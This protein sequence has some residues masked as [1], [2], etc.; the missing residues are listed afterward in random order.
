MSQLGD[1][2]NEGKLRWSLV[3]FESL[4]DMV[5]VL[6]FG[7]NKYS[8]ENWKKGLKWREVIESMLRHIIAFLRG[9]D[10]DKESGISHIGHIMCNAMFIAYMFKNRKDLDNR[11]KT[12]KYEINQTVL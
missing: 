2:F 3:D 1:R 5:K 9:E 8:E 11:F 12:N 6:E 10:Y 4:E 7:A